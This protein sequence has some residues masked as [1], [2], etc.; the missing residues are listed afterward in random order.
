MREPFLE[1][2]GLRKH[3][4][5]VQ[6]L[7][8]VN[9]QAHAGEVHGLVGANGAGKS[10]LIRILAGVTQPDAGTILLDKQPVAITDPQH[11]T[12]LGLSFIHQELNLVPK[13]SV[14]QNM[15]L[16]LPKANRFGLINWRE[17]QREV[18]VA[19]QRVGITF[20]LDTPVGDLS[21]AEQWL[22]SIGR[23]LIRRARL[24]AMDEPTASLSEGETRRLF[25][26]IRELT[27]NGIGILYVSHRLE[28]ILELCTD[29]TVFKDGQAILSTNVSVT[30]KQALVHAIAGRNIDTNKFSESTSISSSPVVLETRGLSAGRRV[31]KVSFSLHRGEVLGLGGLVGSGRTE[32]VRLLFGADQPDAGTIL[33][34]NKVWIPRSPDKAVAN[35][36]G[37]VPEERRRQ[38]LILDKSV[39]FNI[40]LPSLSRHRISSLVPLLNHTKASR[41]ARSI[42][43][44]L[45]VKTQ[46]VD[47]RVGDL[48][49][50]NQQKVVI[51]KW[52]TRDLKVLIL[53]EPTRGV[54]VGARAEIHK[55]IRELSANGVG[56]IVISSEVEELPGLCDRVLVMA[57]GQIAGE[58]VGNAITK[59][60]IIHMCY[61]NAL[62]TIGD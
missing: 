27:A 24:I 40:N 19:A 57:E 16:G 33:L 41:T 23:A 35:G 20:P 13:F 34:H 31:K 12:R 60:S 59:E 28:E 44:R 46:S 18:D 22:V 58:L 14:M 8:G 4:G 1:I 7:K 3:F 26:L 15:T 36:I 25:Q 30:S 32:L 45:S 38:G 21:V 62:N 51:G 47:T 5:G 11:A 43:D 56:V 49:G 61:E 29:I 55:I 6:A 37:F 53:D 39:S 50:G 17:V 9:L 10:T 2:S 42:S 48:S 54:D 52:L